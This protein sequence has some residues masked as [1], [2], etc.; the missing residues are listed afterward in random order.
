M[1][2]SVL[3]RLESGKIFFNSYANF[4]YIPT[5]DELFCNDVENWLENQMIKSVKLSKTREKERN[6]YFSSIQKELDNLTEY[7]KVN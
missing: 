5:R 1:D 3:V 6:Q 2:N 7:I 4:N